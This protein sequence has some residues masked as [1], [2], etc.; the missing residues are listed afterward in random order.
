M[1]DVRHPKTHFGAR[2]D[3][4]MYALLPET[5]PCDAYG[6]NLAISIHKT[7]RETEPWG[8]TGLPAEFRTRAKNLQRAERRSAP[9]QE[10]NVLAAEAH[11]GGVSRMTDP[12]A[13]SVATVGTDALLERGGRLRGGP[14]DP[15]EG[16]PPGMG[17]PD[18][19]NSSNDFA[20]AIGVAKHIMRPIQPV[21]MAKI[22]LSMLTTP[23]R[24]ANARSEA[25]T[26]RRS[27]NAAPS[28]KSAKLNF[29]E[30]SSVWFCRFPLTL[31]DT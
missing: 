14:T 26:H 10:A 7:V 23:V 13:S 4:E 5:S 2:V 18:I 15:E 9:G 31:R 19:A 27:R 25:R 3:D 11:A 16:V 6:L 24:P 30:Q 8:R 21:K 17:E 1:D 22:P 29:C 12:K 20:D 28:A